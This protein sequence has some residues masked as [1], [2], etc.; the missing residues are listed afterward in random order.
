MRNL[1]ILILL[2]LGGCATA[3]FMGEDSLDEIKVD[4]KILQ[5][6]Y[7]CAGVGLAVGTKEYDK[8]LD[9]QLK[10]EPAL[11]AQLD[12]LR[13]RFATQATDGTLDA[14]RQCRNLG[15]GKGSD[16]YSICL[17]YARENI[18]NGAGNKR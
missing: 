3:D 1:S 4:N 10:G 18:K 11:K 16:E 9:D 12:V 14:D 15:Y 13:A 6:E 8:C 7:A 2:L 17:E 5:A